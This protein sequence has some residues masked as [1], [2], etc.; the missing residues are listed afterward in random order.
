MYSKMKRNIPLVI[1][2]KINGIGK[3]LN[4]SKS[5]NLYISKYKLNINKKI[6]GS[7]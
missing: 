6:R 5:N 1:I 3:K 2:K 4:N 7:S